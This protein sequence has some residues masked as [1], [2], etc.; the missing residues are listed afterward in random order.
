MDKETKD[1]I[2]VGSVLVGIIV[3]VYFALKTFIF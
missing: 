3:V 2:I 1:K